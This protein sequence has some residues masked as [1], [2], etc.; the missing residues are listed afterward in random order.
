MQKEKIATKKEFNAV[1]VVVRLIDPKTNETLDTI[2][3][4]I[5]GFDRIKWLSKI[6]MHAIMNNKIIEI[7]NEK[8]DKE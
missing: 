6:T 4:N 2:R 3:K 5:D 7:M 8:D 1:N